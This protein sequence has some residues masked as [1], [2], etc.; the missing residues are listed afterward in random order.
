MAVISS[1]LGALGAVGA[2]IGSA[3]SAVGGALATAG[4]AIGGAL[5]TG[6]G[7]VSTA[8]GTTIGGTSITVGGALGAV[9]LATAGVVG[10]TM[11]AKS[12]KGS[13]SSQ[14]YATMAKTDA[15]NKLSQSGKLDVNETAKTIT[16]NSRMK[17]TLN[18]L[19]IPLGVVPQQ[20]KDEITKNVFGVD[21]NTVA[22][23]TQ[24]MTGLNI[25][26]A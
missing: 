20:D 24:N 25:A 26:I 6:I 21:T 10:A 7:A 4:G 16:E 19:R 11:L 8:L 2:A 23:A 14:Q 1:I 15:L 9:G 12:L 13:Q 17:R 5:S 22:T 3:A 18:S